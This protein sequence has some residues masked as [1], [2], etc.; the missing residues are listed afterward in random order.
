MRVQKKNR[1]PRRSPASDRKASERRWFGDGERAAQTWTP[2]KIGS[3]PGAKWLIF[4][5]FRT[6]TARKQVTSNRTA[7]GE[8]MVRIAVRLAFH[9]HLAQYGG[10]EWA[11]ESAPDRRPRDGIMHLSVVVPTYR[12]AENLRLLVPAVARAVASTG[13]AGE[14]LVVDDDSPDGT[15]E[16]CAELARRHPLRLLVRKNE[17]GLATAV[18]HGLRQAQVG[19]LSVMD[20]DLSHP[21]EKIPDLLAALAAG[22]EFVIGSRYVPG[23]HTDETWGWFRRLNST[24]A[25]A[26]ARGFTSARDPM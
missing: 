16:V 15:P 21:P 25:T 8:G 18:L 19:G 6:K 9:P 24:V 17:R 5:D 11:A 26:L 1:P 3:K 20:A 14:I 12:E 2:P 13:R 23:A 7:A 22:A 10:A 4:A